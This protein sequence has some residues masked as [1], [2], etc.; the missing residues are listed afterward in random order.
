MVLRRLHL[1]SG[2][3][4]VVQKVLISLLNQLIQI[5]MI[6]NGTMMKVFGHVTT[7]VQAI[8]VIIIMAVITIV[9]KMPYQKAV[10]IKVIKVVPRLREEL[11]QALD[12]AVGQK[13]SEDKRFY[14][15]EV[16]REDECEFI[17]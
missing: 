5:V 10:P 9:I 1:H 14:M 3:L 12:L 11:R 8:T 6:G 4:D 17:Y 15:I 13:L 7:I 16:E 2:L